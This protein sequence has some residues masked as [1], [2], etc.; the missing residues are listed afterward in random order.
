MFLKI[1]KMKEEIIKAVQDND[2]VVIKS[3]PGTG[4]TTQIPQFLYD[5]GMRV[6]VV[7]PRMLE[8]CQAYEHVVKQRGLQDDTN[9]VIG[10]RTKKIYKNVDNFGILYCVGG[11]GVISKMRKE[12][13]SDTVIIVDEAHEWKM[14]QE[15]LMGWINAYRSSGNSL[16]VVFM[17]AS[18]NPTEI[19]DYYEKYSSVE[20]IELKEKQFSVIDHGVIARSD[21]IS[22]ALEKASQGKSVLFFCSGKNEI[23]STIDDLKIEME[24]LKVDPITVDIIPLHGSLAFE[25]QKLA[26]E[27]SDNPKIIVC[28]NIAQSGVTPPIQVVI[29]NG[30]EKQIRNINGV[31]NLVEVM[32]SEEDRRQRMGR[33]GRITD[34]EYYRIRDFHHD[35]HDRPQYPVPEIQRLSLDKTIMKL[36][37]M[38]IDPKEMQ[39]FHQ[40]LESA[41]EEAFTLLEDLGAV[42]NGKL[43]EIGKKMITIPTSVQFARI[44]VEAEN[45]KCMTESIK[46]IAIMENGSLLD[47]RNAKNGHNYSDYTDK[48]MKSDVIAEID[49]FDNITNGKYGKDLKKRGLNKRNY[50]G[51]RNRV[52]NLRKILSD[53][54]YDVSSTSSEDFVLVKC[55]FVG[56]YMSLMKNRVGCAL[57]NTYEEW[58]FSYASMYKTVYYAGKYCFG[59]KQIIEGNRYYGMENYIHL[60]LFCTMVTNDELI[61]LIKTLPN[62]KLKVRL[63]FVDYIPEG[64]IVR[65]TSNLQFNDFTIQSD[66]LDVNIDT[67]DGKKIYNRFKNEIIDIE[68]RKKFF[69]EIESRRSILNNGATQN[70]DNLGNSIMADALKKAGF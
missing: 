8:A 17:S 26:F 40:P 45:N 68:N 9:A 41:F 66:M 52:R 42:E 62:G 64:R 27:K 53:Q 56:M 23:Q 14:P 58:N 7:E 38:N 39:F 12:D 18:I 34:G 36:L 10:C 60:L 21:S 35:E 70:T 31:D 22:I 28:T 33:A 5:A 29:D 20:I 43:T 11:F 69:E 49:I 55:L 1:S 50:I 4:K 67:D 48:Y 65:Y 59:V 54:G 51:A 57:S 25:E 6:I 47:I 15:I 44:L 61:D 3:E 13:L 63:N 19:K 37:E 24:C 2:T 46:A 30:L 32:I 16:K